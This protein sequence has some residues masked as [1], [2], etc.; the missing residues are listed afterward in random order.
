MTTATQYVCANEIRR[1]LVRNTRRADGRPVLNGIDF[2]EVASSDQKTLR[3]TFI[4]PLPGQSSAVPPSPAPALAAGNVVIAGG[5]RITGIRVETVRA[6]QNIL[7]VTVNRPGDFSVYTLSLVRS[8]SD[9]TAPAGFDPELAAIEFSFKV[10][11]PSEFDCR[12]EA[13]CAHESQAQPAINYL[14]KD[15]ASFRTVMLDR[16][17]LLVP[18][19][20]ERNPAD[21]GIALVELLAYVAD[22]LSYQQDAIAT[23]AYFGTARRRISVRRHARLVDYSLFEGCNARV[24]VQIRLK[25]GSDNVLLLRKTAKGP[26]RLLTAVE[27]QSPVIAAG[28]TAQE[29][30]MAMQPIVF[31]LM[32]DER[33]FQQHARMTFYTWQN[34]N[35]CLPK[36]ATRATLAGNYPNL[37]KGTVLIFQEMKGPKT[38]LPEDADPLHRYVVR[39]IRDA[40]NETDPLNQQPVAQIE[41]HAEDALPF[42]LCLSSKTDSEHGEDEFED[43]SVA[44]GNI[45]LADHGRT[46]EQ[47]EDLGI[48][49]PPRIFRAPSSFGFA[50][51]GEFQGGGNGTSTGALQPVYPRYRPALKE[52]PLTY[53]APHPFGEV[54]DPLQPARSALQ[55]P[56]TAVRP[57]IV[58]LTSTVESSSTQW[59][60][61]RDLVTDSR[62]QNDCVVEMETDGTAFLR[63]GDGHSGN[64]PVSGSHFSAVYRVGNGIRGNIGAETLGHIIT[65]NPHIAGVANPLPAQGG[66]EPES[67]DE[68]RRNAPVAFRTQD[69][70]VTMDDYAG[71]TERDLR[72]QQAAA[73]LRWTGSW[74]TVFL[75]VD[76][77]GGLMVDP[78]FE[79]ELRNSLER[80][81]LAGQDVEIDNPRFVP[82]E[83]EMHV[84]VQADYF[85]SD[86]KRELLQVLSNR[87][88]PDGR[89][90]VFHPDNFTFG[91]S[92]YLSPVYAAAASVAGVGSVLVTTFQRQGTPSSEALQDGELKLGRLEIARLDNDPNFRDRG[93]L[94]LMVE[95]GK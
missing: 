2:V 38:G 65:E 71:M 44:L 69:R 27:G 68:A 84:C 11:C 53:A 94:R 35:C 59:M 22:Y 54:A 74:H 15:Y 58:S 31:E 25:E 41:W 64:R 79:T 66:A 39:L 8:A 89:L 51:G 86:V 50:P 42:P 1:A 60:V 19:W 9:L 48:V 67:L 81:R 12:A 37:T 17:S 6:A 92:V 30:A 7:T 83:I 78:S 40:R 33:L 5:V 24:W 36:G 77:K 61:K 34:Q 20:K 70:A 43:V 26:V 46:I 23:E 4:H 62:D 32:D 90:G 56:R 82:L 75:T 10:A 85:Q 76:R 63:F 88:L 49:P 80:Y 87:V 3:L 73:S 29:T 91:Q 57:D 21:L 45:V 14:A 16:L 95:G 93:V 18:E 72:V 55:C 28:S 47:E 52:R 13:L